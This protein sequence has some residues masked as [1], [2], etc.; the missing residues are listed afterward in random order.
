MKRLFK[1]VRKKYSSRYIKLLS[2]FTCLTFLILFYIY[3]ESLSIRWIQ[4]SQYWHGLHIDNNI[5]NDFALDVILSKPVPRKFAIMS[6][7]MVD[8]NN[9]FYMLYA[10]ICSLAWRKI[11]YEPILLVIKGKGRSLNKISAKTIEYMGKFKVKVIYVDSISGHEKQIGMLSRL[12]VGILP[13]DL[14]RDEDFVLTTD[15]DFVPINKEYFNFFNTDAISILDARK[16]IFM[17]KAAKYEI[18]EI[19][20]PYIGMKKSQWREVMRLDNNDTLNG[21]T[22]IRKVNEI[23]DQNNFVKNEK[24]ERGDTFW[25]LDQRTI[26]I[27]INEYLKKYNNKAKMNKFP[28]RGLRLNR[29]HPKLWWAML[30][31]FELITDVHMYHSDSFEVR[32][33]IF[34]L[35]NKIF[36][37]NIVNIFEVYF[38]EFRAILKQSE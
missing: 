1:F 7:S 29:N 17:F 4:I 13:E 2:V 23:V 25:Y 22:V 6:V 10:P 27:A 18:P 31:K 38:D 12:F 32:E 19:L 24:L 33:Y 3:K 16:Y 28:Y 26:T 37:R 35:L 21:E 8:K 15:T 20:I 9:F 5:Y 30:E 36:S 11:G 14:I 34:A